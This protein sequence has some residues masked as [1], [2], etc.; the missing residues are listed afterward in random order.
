MDLKIY[1]IMMGTSYQHGISDNESSLSSETNID[2]TYNS[3]D[4]IPIKELKTV[5]MRLKNEIDSSSKCSSNV[6]TPLISHTNSNSLF[7]HESDNSDHDDDYAS[8]VTKEFIDIDESSKMEVFND[9]QKS[10]ITR[11]T[12]NDQQKLLTSNDI[13]DSSDDT[14]SRGTLDLIIPPPKN[15]Q[16]INNPFH[17][18]NQNN[19]K[20][21]KDNRSKKLL[22]TS[23]SD[24]G[25]NNKRKQ[26]NNIILAKNQVTIELNNLKNQNNEVPVRLNKNN[27]Q[28]RMVRT[29]KRRLSAK[30]ILVGPNQEIKRRKMRRR[31]GHVEV[32]IFICL[33]QYFCIF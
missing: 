24:S 33:S 21:E 12:I 19:V 27:E 8:C 4:E 16:G 10:K 30:D 32:N 5:S 23:G 20:K 22:Q 17:N 11:P 13:C 28:F 2:L 31:S 15:F 26:S 3:D 9:T 25:K 6:S 14:S 7:D 1:N 18:N 29:V